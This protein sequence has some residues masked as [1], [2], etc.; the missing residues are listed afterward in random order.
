VLPPLLGA[1][2][3]FYF[4]RRMYIRSLQVYMVRPSSEQKPVRK[5]VGV[6]FFALLPIIFGGI[7][8]LM[9]DRMV[10]SIINE[11][12]ANFL[13]MSSGLVVATAGF[14]TN[15][16]MTFVCTE[17]VEELIKEAKSTRK[18]VLIAS[19]SMLTQASALILIYMGVR[20]ADALSSPGSET[21]FKACEVFA[22]FTIGAFVAGIVPARVKESMATRPG[23]FKRL[24][25]TLAG[26]IVVII[27]LGIALFIMKGG[28]VL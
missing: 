28:G 25:G 10:G 7:C 21:V 1:I 14:F 12:M 6:A 4:M 19:L 8:Y 11:Q 5:L 26:H 13:T 2:T 18:Y 15:L 3:A 23:F 9:V 22:F 17:A 27:G 20:H 24:G 16:G